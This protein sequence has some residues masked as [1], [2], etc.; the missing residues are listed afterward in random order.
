[1]LVSSEEH[2]STPPN[3]YSHSGP[4]LPDCGERS[5]NWKCRSNQKEQQSYGLKLLNR[6]EWATVIRTTLC[7]TAWAAPNRRGNITLWFYCREW[8]RWSRDRGGQIRPSDDRLPRP[9]NDDSIEPRRGRSSHKVFT[10]PSLTSA[11]DAVGRPWLLIATPTEL[12]HGPEWLLCTS[13]LIK[14]LR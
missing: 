6:L 9:I 10:I 2:L 5:G 13:P 12:K 8:W 11:E 1:M 14:P 7:C 3:G 4:A